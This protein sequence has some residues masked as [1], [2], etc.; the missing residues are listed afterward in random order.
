[1]EERRVW[2]DPH[3]DET[4]ISSKESRLRRAAKIVGLVTA[5]IGIP[6]TFLACAGHIQSDW[7][8]GLTYASI[9]CIVRFIILW[10]A[11][12]SPLVGG[13]LLITDGLLLAWFSQ[14][15][16]LGGGIIS[17]PLVLLLVVSGILFIL[18]WREHRKNVPVSR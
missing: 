11:L 9:S 1:M 3:E 5:V 2:I 12:S 10:F 4:K 8:T 15:Y 17:A 6:L 16:I 7:N 18:T 14:K 13:V